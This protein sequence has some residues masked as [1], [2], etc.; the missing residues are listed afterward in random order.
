MQVQNRNRKNGIV[1][2]FLFGGSMDLSRVEMML[3]SDAPV[4]LQN[5]HVAIVGVGGV[6]SYV[7]EALARSGVGFLRLIDGDIVSASNINRQLPALESTMGKSKVQVLYNRIRDI[8][9]S[10]KVEAI[11]EFYIPGSFDHFFSQDIDFI[12]DAIDSIA[13]KVDLLDNCV[14]KQ[15]P[16]I[17]AM[18]TGNKLDPTRLCIGDI[19][20]TSICPLARSLRKRLRERNIVSG[21][22]V[23]YSTEIPH[24]ESEGQT[25][26][27]MVFVPGSAG[28]L[29]ASY[30]V[31]KLLDV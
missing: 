28:L 31:R 2:F 16:V 5:A 26:G 27:S 10:C 14:K 11:E 21:I 15:V 17:S 4:K 24:K 3:G 7:A 25:P 12:A 23:V 29:M 18:G 6:G 30:I 22:P 13:G 9:P 19:G 20:R 8:N 1:G